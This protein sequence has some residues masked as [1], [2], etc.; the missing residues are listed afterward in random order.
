MSVFVEEQ[1]PPEHVD[2]VTN[3]LVKE[4]YKTPLEHQAALVLKLETTINKEI[5]FAKAALGEINSKTNALK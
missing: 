5:S 3:S 4:R 2:M 1:L